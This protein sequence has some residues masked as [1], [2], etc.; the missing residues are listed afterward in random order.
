MTY[1]AARGAVPGP[2][3]L[4]AKGQPLTRTSLIDW[5]QQIM[6]SAQILGNFSSHGFRIG[7]TTVAACSEIPYHLIQT[8]GRWSGNAYQLYIRM[9]AD[10]LAELSQKLASASNMAPG[11][12]PST[13][14]PHDGLG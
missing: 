9:L 12:P 6:T 5:L 3:F 11:G 13:C 14:S 8:I 10:S 2:L 4:F 1:L 7:T